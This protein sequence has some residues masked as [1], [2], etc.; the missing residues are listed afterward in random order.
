LGG[1]VFSW[2]A[3]RHASAP[4]FISI[5]NVRPGTPMKSSSV[6]TGKFPSVFSCFL[7]QRPWL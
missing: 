2:A 5:E 1:H 6:V 7:L 3:M 4:V